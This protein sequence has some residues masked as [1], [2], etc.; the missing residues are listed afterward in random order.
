MLKLPSIFYFAY[1]NNLHSPL[2]T[3]TSFC[4]LF[5]TAPGAAYGSFQARGQIGAAAACLHHSHS[6][7]AT[8]TTAPSNTGYLTH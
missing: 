3:I 6:K 8:Y 4:L 7:S 5:C 1:I 2:Y